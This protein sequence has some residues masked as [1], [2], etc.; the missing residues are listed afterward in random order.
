MPMVLVIHYA[1]FCSFQFPKS[2]IAMMIPGVI[3][4]HIHHHISLTF[5]YKTSNAS[6][7]LL[8]GTSLVIQ[9]FSTGGTV[10]IPGWGTNI[11]HVSRPKNQSTKK[12]RKPEATL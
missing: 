11:P 3:R 5:Y 9:W 6:E 8:S 7:N 12:K 2:H 1:G 4:D 10:S